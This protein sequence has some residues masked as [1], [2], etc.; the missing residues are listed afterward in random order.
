DIDDD[1]ALVGTAAA[2]R[3]VA[4]AAIDI[5]V[6]RIAR[7]GNA[8]REII[9]KMASRLRLSER[10]GRDAKND[11]AEHRRNSRKKSLHGERTFPTGHTHILSQPNGTLVSR[12][13]RRRPCP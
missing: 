7:I 11:D 2:Q 13:K 1:L 5:A 9:D 3:R 10:R 4:G 6:L 12:R 8:D